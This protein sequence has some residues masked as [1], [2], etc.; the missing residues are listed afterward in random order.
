MTEDYQGFGE[1]KGISDQL[2]L[3]LKERMIIDTNQLEFKLINN[4][5]I[6]P[7]FDDQTVLQNYDNVIDFN[8]PLEENRQNILK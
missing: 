2:E 1:N 3:E 4:T 5:L 7:S 6:S 8:K